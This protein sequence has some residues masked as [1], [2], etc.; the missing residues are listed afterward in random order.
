MNCAAIFS[1]CRTYRY[2]LSRDWGSGQAVT[3]IGLNPS[4]ADETSDDATIRRCIGFAKDWGYTRMHM[5]NLFGF[6]AP[7]PKALLEAEDPVGAEN[8]VFLFELAK[9]SSL[10]VA[11]WGVKG[12]YRSRH[13]EVR[14]MLPCLH[15][16]QLTR[17][18]QPQHPLY[19]PRS[20]TPLHWP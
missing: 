2:S 5:V 19:L 1:E 6:C 4:T 20:L 3:F 16:L 10:I 17:N 13:L 9:Q 8:D 15:Y 14:Q 7:H 11:A 18:G 12:T